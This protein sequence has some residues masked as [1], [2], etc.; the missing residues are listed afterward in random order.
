MDNS[1][2]C[3]STLDELFCLPI[4]LVKVALTQDG[5]HHDQPAD[6]QDEQERRIEVFRSGKARYKYGKQQQT[7]KGDEEDNRCSPHGEEQTSD[8]P[9]ENQKRSRAKDPAG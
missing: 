2:S 8:Q 6:R 1:R 5:R 9:T 7:N 4:D 3:A